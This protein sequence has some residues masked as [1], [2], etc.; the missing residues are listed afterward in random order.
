MDQYLIGIDVGTGSARAGVFDRA[1]R[2]LATAKRPIEMHRERGIVAEQSSEQVWR[3][4]CDSV[5]E[6]VARA[7]IDPAQV[8]GIG[9]DATC[10]LV[11]RGAGDA[12]LPVGDP[13]HP[14]R[15]IIV[16]MDHRAVEQ[17]E[18][19][20]AQGHDVLKYVGG[21]ISPEMETP[22]LLWLR[23]NRP[24]TYAAAA[25]FFDLTDFLTWKATGALE[26]SACT[27]TCKWTYLA[28]EGRWDADYF[29]QIGLG[30]LADNGF[31]RIGSRVVDPGTALGAGLTAAAAEAMGLRPGTA[32][33]A[34][35]IDA[36]AGGVGTV[37]A[38]GDATKCLGYVFGTSS[39]TMTT[40][41]EP[42]FVPG[43][44]GPYYS[45]MVPGMWLNEGGQS[46]AGAAID[47]LV[48]LHPATAEATALAEA[49]GKSLP[50]WLADRALD[51]AGE[52]SAAVRLADELHVVPE[53][54]GNRAP[55]A[56]PHARAVVMG[57]GMESG[58]DSLV[59]LYVAGICGLGYGLRQIIET[60]AA[61][62]APVQTI[63]TSGGAGAHPLTRQL[64]ADATGLPVEVTECP[65]PVLLGS[66]MLG[67]V[68]AGV[69]PDL[70]TAMPAMSRIAMRCA[71]DPA[72]RARQ[73]ARHAAFLALQSTARQ[74]RATMAA[75]PS[76]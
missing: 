47:Q 17:A 51:L 41:R 27:V 1:G 15:D 39:C 35:L 62:G 45:A 11:V 43:V 7:G 65:E 34:G 4:V 24:E 13:A 21:R 66:A 57:Q 36:H 64:L 44:W 63:S 68:A 5:R 12:T 29:R 53:F 54:L 72:A 16:W 3:A 6:S 30:D 67:A 32:V 2:L 58:P 61:H 8:A 28:H 55:F 60:Q 26:R 22:K 14:E 18:R 25:H 76:T 49:A 40:T 73:D 20:N 46:A 50:Q 23:E 37:A 42:A 59:A 31:A 38:G 56:D 9:F 52:A 74:I 69:Y 33:A 70:H 75:L 48:Q 71:P 10:S 19:I